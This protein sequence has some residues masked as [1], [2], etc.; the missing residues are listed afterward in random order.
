MSDDLLAYRLL[1]SANLGENYTK[2]VKATTDL[3]Y[4]EMKTKLKSVFSDSGLCADGSSSSFGTKVKTESTDSFY[5]EGD[6]FDVYYTRQSNSGQYNRG[7]IRRR[8]SYRGKRGS[9]NRESWRSDSSTKKLHWE[10]S[11]DGTN[12]KRTDGEQTRCFRCES[13]YHLVNECPEL[14]L[15]KPEVTLITNDIVLCD[16]DLNVGES[17]L[18]SESLNC[19]LLDSGASK[20]VCGEKW[21]NIYV[22]ALSEVEENNVLTATSNN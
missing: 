20:N 4:G 11:P 5:Y 21:W 3:K 12:P 6:E 1:K 7:K 16:E 13:I 10:T 15:I 9:Q 8:K 22:E 2:T 14:E 18:M 17:S 19:A